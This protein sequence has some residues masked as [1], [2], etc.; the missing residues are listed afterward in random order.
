MLNL[1]LWL[2]R[3]SLWRLRL[4]LTTLLLLLLLGLLLFRELLSCLFLLHLYE[5]LRCHACFGG[6]LL[7]LLSLEGLELWDC[8]ASLLCFHC[9]HLLDGLRVQLLR[10]T[11]SRRGTCRRHVGGRQ[12]MRARY[13][14]LVE[15]PAL[16][17][18]RTFRRCQGTGIR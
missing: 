10:P 5:L 16:C 4:T 9:D 14:D 15:K 2:S 6:L 11:R 12:R 1:L 7:D 17:S 8:H 18:T 3:L 13:E